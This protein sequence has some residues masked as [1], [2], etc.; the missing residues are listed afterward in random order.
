[1]KFP[2]NRASVYLV[3]RTNFDYENS[4]SVVVGVFRTAEGA[5]NFKDA[6]SQEWLDR[7]GSLKDVEFSAY[8][9]TFYDD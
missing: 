6:C 2:K 4:E 9:S 1:M 8:A 5:D 3:E 7:V